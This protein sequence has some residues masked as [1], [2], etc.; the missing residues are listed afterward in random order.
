M[1]TRPKGHSVRQEA[2]LKV[3]VF[4]TFT[5]GRM[6]GDLALQGRKRNVPKVLSPPWGLVGFSRNPG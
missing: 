3:R 4:R 2:K 1:I 5:L 6:A